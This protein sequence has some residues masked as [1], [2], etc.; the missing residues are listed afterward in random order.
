MGP[1]HILVYQWV[2]NPQCSAVIKCAVVH[3]IA[4]CECVSVVY[5]FRVLEMHVDA[6]VSIHVG[7]TC[8]YFM[9]A[10]HTVSCACGGRGVEL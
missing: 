7:S 1:N 4:H 10:M 5:D 9:L 2:V 8:V 6:C 3:V